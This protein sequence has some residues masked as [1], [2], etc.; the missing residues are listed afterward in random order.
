MTGRQL[1][2][3]T[4]TAGLVSWMT[5][6]SG[7]QQLNLTPLSVGPP[8]TVY[9]NYVTPRINN[10]GQV[11]GNRSAG[12]CLFSGSVLT[13]LPYSPLDI[14]NNGVITMYSWSGDGYISAPP[15]SSQTNIG[16]LPPSCGVLGSNFATGLN[17]SGT[18]VGIANVPT[19]CRQPF[20]YSNG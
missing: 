11:I 5:V 15:Y 2:W 3:A 13:T 6:R 20:L 14:N 9:Y 19:S 10:K 12:G 4:L 8:T 7:A 1:L 16:T 18:A 17:D